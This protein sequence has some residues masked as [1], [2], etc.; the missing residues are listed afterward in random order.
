MN[1]QQHEV[2]GGVP[3]G[4]VLKALVEKFHADLRN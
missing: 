3:R 1:Y 4:D 2:A